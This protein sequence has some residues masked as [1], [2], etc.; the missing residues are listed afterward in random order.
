MTE[1]H[2]YAPGWPGIPPRWTSSAKDG[3]GTS[4]NPAS[5]VWFTISHGILNEI[6]YPRVDLACIRDMGMLVTD[7]KEYFSEEKRTARQSVVQLAPGV[8]A[9][10]MENTSEDGSFRIEKEILTDPWREVLLQKTRFVPLRGMLEMFRLYVL[11]APHIANAGWGNTGWLGDYKEVQ[12][13][14]AERA[15]ITLALAYSAGWLNRSVGFVGASE[16]PY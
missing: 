4:L 7:G 12:M 16:F 2:T 15:G 3:V 8:P 6:Y 5:R 10:R 1:L 13:L 9:Y 11:L 14:S